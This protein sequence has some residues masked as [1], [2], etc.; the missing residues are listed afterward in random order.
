MSEQKMSL[1]ERIA[2]LEEQLARRN[3]RDEIENLVAVHQ[4]YM[5]ANQGERAFDE[6]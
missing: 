5:T 2:R 6:L 3:D 1:E 4:H